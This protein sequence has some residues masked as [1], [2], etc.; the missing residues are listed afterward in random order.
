MDAVSYQQELK[1]LQSETSMIEN[2]ASNIVIDSP[3]FIKKYY[4]YAIILIVNFVLLLIIKPKIILKI[5]V[6]NKEP[7]MLINKKMFVLVYII[8]DIISVLMYYIYSRRK[9]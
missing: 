2:S 6:I 7:V 3:S 5:D 1:K 4:V 9:V 8:I